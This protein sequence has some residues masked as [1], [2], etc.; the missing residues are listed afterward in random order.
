MVVRKMLKYDQKCDLLNGNAGGALAL[1][2]LYELTGDHIYLSY[3]EE[4]ASDMIEQY[5]FPVF[6]LSLRFVFFHSNIP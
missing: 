2:N 5:L 4:A 1:I 3:A 6:F